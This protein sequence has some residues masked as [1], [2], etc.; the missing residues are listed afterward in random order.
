LRRI[1]RVTNE[2]PPDRKKRKTADWRGGSHGK[3]DATF[4]IEEFAD[5]NPEPDELVPSG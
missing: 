3:P 1:P 4:K 5:P 2:P